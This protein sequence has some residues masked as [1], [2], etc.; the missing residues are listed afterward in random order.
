MTDEPD[1][2]PETLAAHGGRSPDAERGD[3]APP[4]R[5]STNYARDQDY[6]QIGGQGGYSRADSPSYPEIESLLARLEGGAGAMV[7]ASGMAAATAV[8]LSLAP[9]DHVVLPKVVYWGLREWLLQFAANWG[10]GVD[11]FDQGDPAALARALKP[12]ATKLVWIE[13]PCN[14]T[15]DV[16]D[17]AAAAEAAHAAGARLAVDSTV[18]TPVLTQPIALGADLVF[19]SGTK[20]LNGH[21][22]VMAGVLVTARADDFWA[23]LRDKRH[24]GGGVL[25]AFEAWLLQR[26]LRTLYLRVGRASESALAIARHFEGHP[27]LAAVLYP[28]LESHPGHAIAKR[29]M[30]GGFGGMLSLRM[31]GGAEGALEVA[32]R[33][34]IFVR[35]TSLGGVESLIEHRASIEGPTSPVPAD[36]LRLSIGIEDPQDLIADLEQALAWAAE[37]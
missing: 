31:K 15:W 27:K 32:R 9:G 17:I 36:L 19:H 18:A 28:G 11:L 23:K 30:T 26:G 16:I 35:A 22:D 1:L 37:N 24:R 20:Y 8:W 2:K 10:L 21:G 12:G 7:F 14:P 25:G 29:Q 13:S 6:R 5:P 4:L 33:V 34:R 3:V